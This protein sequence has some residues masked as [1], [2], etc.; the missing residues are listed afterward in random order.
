MRR[1]DILDKINLL[2]PKRF[3][4]RKSDSGISVELTDD[5]EVFAEV[6]VSLLFPLTDRDS[7]LRIIDSDEKEIGLVASIA[8]LDD[9][10]V[11]VIESELETVYFIPQIIRINDVEDKFGTRTWDVETERGPRVFDVRGR[12]SVRFVAKGHV[13]VK[14]VDGNRFEIRDT[15]K[16]DPL[17]RQL[18]DTAV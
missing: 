16:L 7:F 17:S 4:V 2:D 14:D 1:E 18:M 12:E 9:E 10:S 6:S 5:G 8:D 3:R 13:V 11:D 15:S